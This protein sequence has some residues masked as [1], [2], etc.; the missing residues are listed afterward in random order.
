M[1]FFPALPYLL[2]ALLLPASLGQAKPMKPYYVQVTQDYVYPGT[3]FMSTAGAVEKVLAVDGKFYVI[4]APK[5]NEVKL[6]KKFGQKIT[7]SRAAS[8]LL[9][10]RE[11]LQEQLQHA[12][13]MSDENQNARIKAQ[14]ELAAERRARVRTLL[15]LRKERE[16]NTQT[17]QP[18][19]T[20]AAP[21]LKLPSLPKAAPTPTSRTAPP[22]PKGPVDLFENGKVIGGDQ[23]FLGFVTRNPNDPHSLS[24]P[25]GVYGNPIGELSIFNKNG[26]YGN[27]S[28]FLSANYPMAENPPKIIQENGNWV[29]LTANQSMEN[30]VSME[31][32]VNWLNKGV[33]Q[34]EPKK[35]DLALP[36]LNF[37]FQPLK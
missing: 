13:G 9:G 36:P 3:H 37:D 4:Q 23:V 17:V 1:K 24:N 28:Y 26:K 31:E 30:R 33:R 20:A 35:F 8:T 11:L 15:E 6:P 2:L 34:P 25:N 14:Q 29:Y 18:Q 19:R 16:K 21:T 5:G 27:E 12:K 10:E 32:L 7:D 22:P